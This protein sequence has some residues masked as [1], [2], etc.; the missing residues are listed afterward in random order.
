M[1]LAQAGRP[2]AS[3]DLRLTAPSG[4]ER[5]VNVSILS[6]DSAESPYLVHL[7]RDAQGRHGRGLSTIPAVVD[8]VREAWIPASSASGETPAWPVLVQRQAHPECI[9]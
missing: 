6:V 3:Y 5:W 9:G 7:L 2:V 8:A 4:P 1:K